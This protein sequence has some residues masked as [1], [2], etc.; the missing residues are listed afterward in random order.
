[1][2]EVSPVR[3]PSA[4]VASRAAR[5]ARVPGTLRLLLLGAAILHLGL[6]AGCRQQ[7]TVEDMEAATVEEKAP[8]QDHFE[9]GI[10]FLKM[11]DRH[12]LE[13]S[14]SQSSYHFNRWLRGQTADPRWIIDRRLLTT[15]PDTIRRAPATQEILGDRSLAQLEFQLSDIVVLEETRW[16]Q[17]IAKY[18][19]QAGD[20][21]P[22]LKWIPELGLPRRPTQA[23]IAAHLLFD[24]TIRNVQLDELLAY[25]KTAV[26]GPAADGSNEDPTAGWPPPMQAIPG[27]G[28]T[29]HPWHVL[30]YGRGDAYQRA[31]VFIG[32]L[33]QLRIDAVMLSIDTKIGRAQ[34]WLPAVLIENELYLFDPALGLAI[35]GPGGVGTATL[36]QALA[37]P[38]ILASLNIGDSYVYPVQHTNLD[39]VVALLD[40]SPEALSQRMLLIEQH[41]GAADQMILTVSASELARAVRECEGIQDVRLWAVPIEAAIYQRAYADLVM[42]DG[43]K[44]WED[45]VAHGVFQQL[46]PL[47]QGRRQYLL[48]HFQ[49][50][51]DEE[52][53]AHYFQVARVTDSSLDAMEESRRV[54]QEMGLERPLGMSDE[55]WTQRLEQIKR[56]QVES[57]QHA[58]Y[59]M[60]LLHQQQG[61]YE[62]AR[63]WLATRTLER[64]PDGPWTHGARYNLARC[65][66]ALGALAEAIKLYRIDES[67]QRHG[68]LLRADQLEGPATS[69]GQPAEAAPAG[70]PAPEQPAAS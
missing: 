17:A 14:A 35:P 26:A 28:Y 34:P 33:R 12:N 68:S 63:N 37:D 64:Y 65:D 58:S 41:L 56:L 52:G 31:R 4:P 13:R 47:V 48:G 1:M 2:L 69:D 6:L 21:H 22:R 29:G 30:M 70:E 16:L 57:K 59:W 15:L 66:E 7:T 38:A 44:Q 51:G 39:Q 46:N 5:A 3:I 25:P 60:G 54:Q 18:A 23:L 32:L 40:A 43:Q 9:M 11:R 67:P 45:F 10:D 50:R 19:S 49:K 27:P 8:E 36:K 55:D 20:D 24:W 61:N 62:V 53:A 42:R